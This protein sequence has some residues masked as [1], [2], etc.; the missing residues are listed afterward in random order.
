VLPEPGTQS[1][2]TDGLL[3]IE[4]QVAEET[5]VAEVEFLVDG[6]VVGSI[7][8]APFSLRWA[9]ETGEH[10]IVVRATDLAGNVGESAGVQ[11]EIPD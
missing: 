2:L 5:G 6:E 4:A 11:I 10:T 7:D 3:V 1:V 9:A 8:S